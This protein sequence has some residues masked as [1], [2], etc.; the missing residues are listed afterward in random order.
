MIAH[1]I[2]LKFNLTCLVIN[3]EEPSRKAT[4][5]A[6]QSKAAKSKCSCKTNKYQ[7]QIIA[8]TV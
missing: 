3:T 2:N 5:A 7:L 1:W 8:G 4:D 6:L